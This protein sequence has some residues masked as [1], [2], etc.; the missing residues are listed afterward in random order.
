MWTA[1]VHV[2]DLQGPYKNHWL[3]RVV[4]S[5]VQTSVHN[6]SHTRDIESTVQATDTITGQG[7]A[8]HVY[9]PIELPLATLLCSLGV[10]SQTCTSIVQR[11]NEE[12][13]ASTS[14]SS[15][16]QVPSKPLPV[17]IFVL[18]KVEHAFEVVLEGKV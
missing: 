2:T 13:R 17:P 15:R 14:S 6:D 5:K 1:N 12:E 11:I 16:S 7:L 18:L 10:I 9:D 8:I 4:H 3:E